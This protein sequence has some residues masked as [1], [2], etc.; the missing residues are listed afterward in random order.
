MKR[1]R[2]ASC[3][4]P[5]DDP[6]MIRYHDEEWGTPTH[7]DR[8]H[9]EYLI[10]DANQAGLSWSTVLHKR[11]AFRRAFAGFDFRKVAE[12]GAKDVRR[13][14]ADKGIIRNRQ[15]IASAVANAKAFMAVRREFGTFDA[16]VWRFVG[17]RTIVNRPK[18][19]SNIAAASEEAE[20]M[21]K[22][23][24]KR[25]FSFVGPVICYAYMQGAGL[26]DDHLARCFRKKELARLRAQQGPTL[27]ERRETR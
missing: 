2:N 15:K 20:A 19:L 16:Y 7:D 22:D 14:M 18:E 23:M 27:A 10:L 5:G 26:V 17:G 9:F 1:K 4:W 12:F 21:S 24:K 13:L 11:G 25:G 3:S 6:D 8:R